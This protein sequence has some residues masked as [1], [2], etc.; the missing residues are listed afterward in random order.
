MDKQTFKELLKQAQLRQI[1]NDIYEEHKDSAVRTN[2]LLGKYQID[3]INIPD[4]YRRIVNY[5][6]RRYGSQLVMSTGMK[7]TKE[8][9]KRIGNNV[10][11][12]KRAKL[13]K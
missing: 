12:R 2:Y 1:E 6:I 13:K 11:N 7:L 10:R 5:Q 9:I 8:D 4:V 3:G